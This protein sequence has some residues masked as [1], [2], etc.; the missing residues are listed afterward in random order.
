MI[1][2]FVAVICVVSFSLPFVA[3]AQN[4][5]PCGNEGQPSCQTCH[6]IELV[7]NVTDWLI[8]VLGTVAAIIIVYAGF[9]LVVAGGSS[10]ARADAKEMLVNM[11]VGYVIVLA[12][13]L[14]IDT[15]MRALLNTETVGVWNQIQCTTQPD[16]Q[17]VGEYVPDPIPVVSR[18]RQDVVPI[19]SGGTGGGA[20]GTSGG[21]GGTSGGGGGGGGSGTCQVVSN[22][23]NACH[24]SRLTCFSDRNL[25]SEI[26]NVESAGGNT[27]IMSRT[28]LCQDGRSFSVGLWQINIL[29]NRNLIPGCTGTFFTS[30]NGG[31]SEGS[32]I[33]R[34]T[35]RNGI[36]YCQFR[37]CRI[38]NT[39]MYNY[40]V[41]QARI[42][43]VNTTA[44]CRLFNT[45]GWGAWQT[46]YNRCR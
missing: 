6:V 22:I 42:P 28:D 5:V 2:G 11:L 40:C 8:V 9:K 46:S 12:G 36:S 21:S 27:S 37:S 30:D 44:A 23:S 38:T 16:P 32:C 10:S 13:W 43:A 45:Q 3:S 14:V 29:A 41:S 1:R 17:N 34:T 19:V 18:D 24:P 31:R 39:T 20:G 26:C 7:N 35:N 4:F 25:A 33:R 15:A